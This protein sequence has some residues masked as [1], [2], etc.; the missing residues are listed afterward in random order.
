MNKG[1]FSEENSE[2]HPFPVV[3]TFP[4][5]DSYLVAAC[6]KADKNSHTIGSKK[7]VYNIFCVEIFYLVI[8]SCVYYCRK[9][10]DRKKESRHFCVSGKTGYSSH[11]PCRLS[12]KQHLL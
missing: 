5:L 11:L 10:L 8:Y 12:E 9:N 7:R 6:L 1:C 2:Q 4:V 3:L